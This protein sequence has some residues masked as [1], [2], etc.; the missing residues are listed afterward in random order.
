MEVKQVPLHSAMVARLGDEAI[1]HQDRF[2][3]RAQ[4]LAYTRLILLAVGMSSFWRFQVG[5]APLD[6]GALR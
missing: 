3:T 2:V 5:L 6:L 4:T 1:R